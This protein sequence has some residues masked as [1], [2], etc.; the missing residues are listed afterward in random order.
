MII[1]LLQK[2]LDLLQTVIA[3][4]IVPGVMHQN[5]MIK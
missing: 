2:L 5:V 3:I 1:L 4:I